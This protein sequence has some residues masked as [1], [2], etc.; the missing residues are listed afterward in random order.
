[1]GSEESK[2]KVDHHGDQQIKIIN[3]QIEHSARLDNHELI[4]Y[5]ILIIVALTLA[6][7]V[8]I[9]FK[10]YNKRKVMKKAKTIVGL[11]EVQVNK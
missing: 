5:A 7:N 8:V 1:M 2:S 3:T 11:T 9:E 10:R 6:L 4:L